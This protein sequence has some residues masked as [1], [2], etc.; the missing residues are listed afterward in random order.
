LWVAVASLLCFCASIVN[1]NHMHRPVFRAGWPNRSLNLA[2]TLARG[3]TASGIVVPHNLNH[4]VQTNKRSDWIRPDLAGKGRGGVRRCRSGLAASLRLAWA[5]RRA[6]APRLNRVAYP[7]L[8]LERIVLASA[9]GAALWHDWRVFAVYIAIPWIAGLGML[10]GV[11]LLQHDGCNEASPLGESRN[12][13]GAFGNWL[14]F[15]NGY[16]TA[17]H[18]DPGCHWS[19]LPALHA[20]IRARLPCAD[21]EHGSILSYLWQFGWRRNI[22]PGPSGRVHG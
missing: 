6:G 20:Q 13:T 3:H 22:A 18:R 5:R 9:I 17:H 7:G 1:H 4:H 14:L 2:L 8:L 21:L 16:H 19:E 11:N 10:V 15:N 12:F